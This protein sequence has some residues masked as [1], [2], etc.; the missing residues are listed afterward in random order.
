VPFMKRTTG[1]DNIAFWIF[2]RAFSERKR[3]NVKDWDGV[4]NEVGRDDRRR[5]S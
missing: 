4:S 5:G 3:A 2:E 1:E